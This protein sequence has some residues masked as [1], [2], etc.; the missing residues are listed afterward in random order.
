VCD[1]KAQLMTRG[2]CRVP[3]SRR[4]LTAMLHQAIQVSVQQS[5]PGAPGG[6]RSLHLAARPVEVYPVIHQ[7]LPRLAPERLVTLANAQ[8]GSCSI[9]Q[10]HSMYLLTALLPSTIASGTDLA[11]ASMLHFR[12]P[13]INPWGGWEKGYEAA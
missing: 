2:W 9:K 3:C 13:V 8:S 7:V 12:K 10:Y 6:L 11:P 1:P 5:R 4:E